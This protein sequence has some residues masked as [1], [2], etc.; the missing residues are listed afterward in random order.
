MD[1]VGLFKWLDALLFLG[2]FK[3]DITGLTGE[4]FTY[5][6]K[7]KGQ[8]YTTFVAYSHIFSTI[9]YNS[10]KRNKRLK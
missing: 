7:C 9:E 3:K 5:L 2:N 1:Y 10:G 4:C 6:A 8:G